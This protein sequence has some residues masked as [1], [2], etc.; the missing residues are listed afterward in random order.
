MVLLLGPSAVGKMTV[1]QELAKITG[2]KLL[3]HNM[4][5]DLLTDLFPFGTP[6]YGRLKRQ[7]ELALIDAAAETGTS[8]VFTFGLVFSAPN[9]REIIEELS[10]PYTDRGC[11]VSYV[12][13]AAPLDVRLARNETENRHANKKTDWSTADQLRKLDG[14]GHWNSDGDFPYP[15]RHLLIETSDLSAN[16]TARRIVE[17]FALA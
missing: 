1:G 16:E 4:V 11:D 2:Y 15:E 3:T 17:R 10:A 5:V 7:F 9:A 14:W 8:L 12:E 6:A 13:L